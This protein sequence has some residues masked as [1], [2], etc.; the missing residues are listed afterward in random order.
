MTSTESAGTTPGITM[1]SL[2][3]RDVSDVVSCRGTELRCAVHGRIAATSEATRLA[4]SAAAVPRIVNGAVCEIEWARVWRVLS[5]NRTNAHSV[6]D[7]G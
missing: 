1:S 5:V 2:F 7:P 3:G 4:R 6:A